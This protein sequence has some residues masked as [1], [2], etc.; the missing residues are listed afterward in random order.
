M[1]LKDRLVAKRRAEHVGCLFDY[2]GERDCIDHPREAVPVGVAERKCQRRQGFAAARRHRQRKQTGPRG[3]T[4]AAGG[5][6]LRAE[7]VDRRRLGGLELVEI[8][9]QTVTES[10]EFGTSCLLANS[11][12]S[13]LR[14]RRFPHGKSYYSPIVRHLGLAKQ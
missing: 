9:I 2:A 7:V 14:S 4:G 10:V 6:D 12:E 1:V 3:G 5:E 8:R 13:N 11:F